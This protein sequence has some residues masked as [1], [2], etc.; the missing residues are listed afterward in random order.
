MLGKFAKTKFHGFHYSKNSLKF[1]K[2]L[3]I[4]YFNAISKFLN[5]Q[6]R[7]F[8]KIASF[9]MFKKIISE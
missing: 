3:Q 2:I 7:Y 6:K 8:L 4:Q 1:Y 5:Y 9:L